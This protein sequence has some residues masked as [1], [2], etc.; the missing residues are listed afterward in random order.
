MEICH[1]GVFLQ[2]HWPPQKRSDNRDDYLDCVLNEGARGRILL[3]DDELSVLKSLRILLEVEGF[4][5]ATAA[6]GTEALGR[7]MNFHFHLVIL[8]L[9]LPD[10]SGFDLIDTIFASSNALKIVVVSGQADIETAIRTIKHGAHDYIRKPYA[11]EELIQSVKNTFQQLFLEQENQRISREL[12]N[13][14]RVYR[15]LVDNSPD[16][17]FAVNTEGEFTFV[18]R[19]VETLLGIAPEALIGRHFAVIVDPQDIDTARFVFSERRVGERASCDVEL[20][21][22]KKITMNS[23]S[24]DSDVA[25]VVSCSSFGMYSDSS[26]LDATV[27]LGAYGV[28]RDITERKRSEEAISYRAHHDV[29]TGLPNRVLLQDRIGVAIKQAERTGLFVAVLFIDLDG[30]KRINDLFGHASGDAVLQEVGRRLQKCLRSADTLAR[31]G[32]DEFAV[33]LPDLQ[34]IENANVIAEKFLKSLRRPFFVEGV[35][36]FVTGSIGIAGFPRDGRACEQLLRSADSA[37]YQVKAFGKDNSAFFCEA[38][39]DLEKADRK[40][41]VVSAAVSGTF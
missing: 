39:S 19:R 28:A 26:E 24:A 38:R 7:L 9:G 13:T 40:K 16:F 1:K 34:S 20:K 2:Q 21:L 22:K 25:L 30:F 23:E 8:D 5:V 27:Y 11:V 4:Q 15:Y 31:F 3:V 41:N 29:L 10:C 12:Q 14:E 36:L 37:M 35:E 18:N 32:V 6:S 17:V 33:V